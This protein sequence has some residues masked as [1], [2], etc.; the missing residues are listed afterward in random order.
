MK[1]VNYRAVRLRPVAAGYPALRNVSEEAEQSAR[2]SMKLRTVLLAS[3]FAAF[4]LAAL[5]DPR[6]FGQTT[7]RQNPPLVISS[8]AGR[9]LFESYCASCHGRDGKGSGPV[10]PALKTS[11]P[12]LTTITRRT[13]ATFP[14]ARVESF[15]TGNGDGL[16]PAHGSKEM[17]VWGPIF[18][19]LDPRD[20]TNKVRISN[21]VSYIESLQS[22]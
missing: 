14:R 1:Q 18:R 6:A 7:G 10:A 2:T 17:P 12:D 11:P 20:A 22:R 16:T 3:V 19:G 15:V 5:F 21:I 8:M 13:G 4:L 9:D